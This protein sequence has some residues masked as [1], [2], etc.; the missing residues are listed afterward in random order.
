MRFFGQHETR[1][2]RQR[3]E[4]GFRECRELELAVAIGKEGE[5]VE[6]QPIGRSLVERPEDARVVAITGTPHK[7]R[8]GFFSTV[9]AEMT[10]EQINHRPQVTPFFDVYLK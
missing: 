4:T 3:I 10:L 9:P 2:A 1:G 6:R 8:I 5:H 7:K